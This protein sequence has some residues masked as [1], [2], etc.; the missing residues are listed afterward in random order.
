MVFDGL[1]QKYAFIYS[2]MISSLETVE[3]QK[4]KLKGSLLKYLCTFKR[5]R[6]EIFICSYVNYN[7]VFTTL[8]IKVYILIFPSTSKYNTDFINVN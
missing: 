6:L 7:L 2:H 5:N 3:G 8:Q 4:F 1:I